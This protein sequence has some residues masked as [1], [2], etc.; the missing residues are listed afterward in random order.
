MMCV[1][2]A[3]MLCMSKEMSFHGQLPF[4]LRLIETG[5]GVPSSW[6]SD[7]T[8]IRYCT[9]GNMIPYSGKGY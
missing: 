8:N 6:I 5:E 4:E 9:P 3:F 7:V 1:D 2:D